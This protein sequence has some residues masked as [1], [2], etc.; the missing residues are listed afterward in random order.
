MFYSILHLI[1]GLRV[2]IWLFFK[3]LIFNNFVFYSVSLKEK[4]Y[5]SLIFKSLTSLYFV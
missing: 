4:K 1:L 2:K 5:Y 3:L